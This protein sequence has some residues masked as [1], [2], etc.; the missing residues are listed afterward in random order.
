MWIRTYLYYLQGI[1]RRQVQVVVQDFAPPPY[2]S[3][4]VEEIV[5]FFF[6]ILHLLFCVY[7]HINVHLLFLI[8]LFARKR[9]R[10]G[11]GI[12]GPKAGIKNAFAV[13]VLDN[14]S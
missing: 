6:I 5:F 10:E 4:H 11:N 3:S 7:M 1:S 12:A 14:L 13:I 8:Y 9:C 2:H